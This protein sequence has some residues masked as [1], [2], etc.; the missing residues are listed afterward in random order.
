M[1][2]IIIALNPSMAAR[3]GLV[4]ASG[5]VSKAAE[6]GSTSCTAEGSDILTGDL[7]A[8]VP[9]LCIAPSALR[10]TEVEEDAVM[11]P[12]ELTP[13]P[14]PKR[15]GFGSLLSLP[16][17]FAD[18]IAVSGESRVSA[19]ASVRFEGA[20]VRGFRIIARILTELQRLTSVPIHIPATPPI[21]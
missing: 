18:M 14:F 1:R 19:E 20:T 5:A 4:I 6:E 17:P 13:R 3:I 7:A 16:R 11:A 10:V 21:Q 9:G 12:G 2:T 15:G 8:E